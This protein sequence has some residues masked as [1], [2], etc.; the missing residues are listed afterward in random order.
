MFALTSY[1]SYLYL[2][3]F[4]RESWSWFNDNEK[5][6]S[7][8]AI[9]DAAVKYLADKNKVAVDGGVEDAPS[10]ENSSLFKKTVNAIGRGYKMVDRLCSA[11][12]SIIS[13]LLSPVVDYLLAYDD[14]LIN[15]VYKRILDLLYITTGGS[16]DVALYTKCISNLL[17]R[18]RKDE[19]VTIYEFYELCGYWDYLNG[20]YLSSSSVSASTQMSSLMKYCQQWESKP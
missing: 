16:N 11:V 17:E 5:M 9:T 14:N 6:W 20:Q 13:K 12:Y 4:E 1:Y 2:D 7:E 3:L 19:K 8:D 18:C 15:R 10:D